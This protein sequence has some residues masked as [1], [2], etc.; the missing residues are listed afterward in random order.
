MDS[1]YIQNRMNIAAAESG[2]HFTST[3]AARVYGVFSAMGIMQAAQGYDDRP[4]LTAQEPK[5][6]SRETDLHA[7]TN[8]QKLSIIFIELCTRVAENWQHKG[9]VGRTI[10]IKLRYEDFQTVTRDQIL[11]CP[12]A[13]ASIIRKA[14]GNCLRRVP[15]EHKLRL[16]GVRASNL[17]CADKSLEKNYPV[18][19]V[20]FSFWNWIAVVLFPAVFTPTI[21][22]VS[23]NPH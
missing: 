16:L 17:S 1:A 21:N 8:R 5:S 22:E 10:G 15:L 3:Y 14:A 20:L 7:R 11:Q 18:Q 19:E 13:D 9:Y 2:H 4:V 12:T 23:H 6:I